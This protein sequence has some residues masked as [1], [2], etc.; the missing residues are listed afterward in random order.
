VIELWLVVSTMCWVS[1]IS[2]NLYAPDYW[3]GRSRYIEPG[4][5]STVECKE[6][7][8]LSTSTPSPEVRA[9]R[10][11]VEEWP[12][13]PLE[14]PSRRTIFDYDPNTMKQLE[15]KDIHPRRQRWAK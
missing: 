3:A 10:V 9:Y 8:Q 11:I 13:K 15:M 1:G 6:I 12:E 5:Y 14:I 7:V 4:I 2:N